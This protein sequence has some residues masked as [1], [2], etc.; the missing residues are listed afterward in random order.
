MVADP[1]KRGSKELCNIFMEAYEQAV[2]DGGKD[3]GS[4]LKAAE[5]IADWFVESKQVREVRRVK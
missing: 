4:A 3:S 2:E 1:S 5:C